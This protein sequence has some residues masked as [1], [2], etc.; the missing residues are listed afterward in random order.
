LY[1]TT[2]G[3]IN[4][5]AFVSMSSTRHDKHSYITFGGG[6]EERFPNAAERQNKRHAKVHTIFWVALAAALLHAGCFA[7]SIVLWDRNRD[8]QSA[9]YE[10]Y[11]P[12]FVV[13]AT[14]VAAV[15][16]K[17]TQ[18]CPTSD[19]P[20][21]LTSQGDFPVANGGTVRGTWVASR[22]IP[23]GF[24]HMNGYGLLFLIFAVSFVSQVNV[25]WEYHKAVI[26]NNY[27]F[28]ETPCAARWSE[29][30][31]TSPCQVVI[32]AACLMLR[33]VYTILL[34]SAAQAALV[35]FGFAME[36]AYELRA[37]EQIENGDT[38]AVVDGEAV[39][40]R[41]LPMMPLLITTPKLSQ[42]LWYWS[43]VP[44]TFLHIVIWGVLFTAFVEQK[45]CSPSDGEMPKFV[46]IILGGQAG[47]FTSFMFVALWQ[48]FKLDVIPFRMS[49]HITKEDVQDSFVTSFLLYT[50]LSAVAKAMLGITYLA[51]VQTFPF[52]TPV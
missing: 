46:V 33:D 25:V 27:S 37:S 43:F 48:A 24:L 3:T 32:I 13:N 44:A 38:K 10:L 18:S 28:F 51:Y 19:L 31:F 2:G 12:A 7:A 52:Y 6:A 40:F 49:K 23:F 15:E 42:Q 36:C 1:D 29:Y 11:R 34:L 20:P 16:A 4:T 17:L 30:F 47:A 14:F 45:P 41:P 50:I 39:A 8:K 22:W 35:Q 9:V 21:I 26:D 5:D